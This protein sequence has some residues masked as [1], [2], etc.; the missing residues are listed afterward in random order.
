[1]RA[2]PRDQLAS[3]A[4]A[5]RGRPLHVHL[6]EQP[7]ENEAC[8]AAYG[9]SPAALLEAAGV[10]GPD[11][12]AVHAV[13]LSPA[14]V[15]ALTG[16]RTAVCACPSTEADLADGIGPFRE[17]ADDGVELVLGSDS[18]A[19]VD[20]FTEA[21]L[22]EGHERLRSGRRG[23][24]APADLVTALTQAGHA[25]LGWPDA[26]RL[27]PGARADLVAVDLG[28][29][30]TAGA[31]PEQVVTVASAADVRSVVVDGRVVVDEGRHALGDVG[32]LL[33]EAVEPLWEGA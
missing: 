14:D 28:S 33:A 12:T 20:L 1:V 23:R 31:A 8:R 10:L 16:S 27:A 24:F 11:T 17:L 9:A 29:P 21:R 18:H 19:V 15:R 2:V 6:S 25:A 3:V 13:H 30:R 5:A 22:L 32:R 26:G 7:A 4:A